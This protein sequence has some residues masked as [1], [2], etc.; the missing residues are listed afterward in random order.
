[1]SDLTFLNQYKNLKIVVAPLNW[2]L[3]HAT[4]SSKLIDILQE[5]NSVSIAS[6]GIAQTWLKEKYPHLQ[7]IELPG[8][9]IHYRSK[10]MWLNMI[11]W[12]PK[13]LYAI[14]KEHDTINKYVKEH[15]IDLIISDHRLGCHSRECKSVILA[16][17]IRI[18]HSNSKISSIISWFNRL[19]MNR[20]EEVWVPDYNNKLSGVLSEAKELS[21]KEDIG[22]LT[23]MTPDPTIS[24]DIDIAVVLSGP[25]PSRRKLEQIISQSI[26]D[27]INVKKVLIRGTNEEID[28]SEVIYAQYD[29]IY[30][31]ANTVE[32]EN[33]LQRSSCIVCRSGYT[34]I[35]DL[36]ALKKSAILIPTPGQP[37]Q[38]YL[39]RYHGDKIHQHLDQ[40]DIVRNPEILNRLINQYQMSV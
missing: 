34:T 27:I 26:L 30:N 38:E 12:L 16:H 15:S 29:E 33:I 10:F 5:N 20:F 4:R 32:V 9:K 1:M 17:Q 39:A 25:E 23:C 3:G 31:L 18:L 28:S 21:Q 7:H 40:N 36:D 37:E 22:P 24:Q 13:M 14:N 11:S 35:M 8:Y 6:D 19:F 2:G